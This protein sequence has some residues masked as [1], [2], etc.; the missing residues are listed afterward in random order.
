MSTCHFLVLAWSQPG[1]F[2]SWISQR[3][4]QCALKSHKL[5]IKKSQLEHRRAYGYIV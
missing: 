2:V 1:D 3:Y 4:C 5:K